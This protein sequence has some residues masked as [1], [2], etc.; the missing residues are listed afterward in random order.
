MNKTELRK[1]ILQKRET[2]PEKERLILKNLLSMKEFEEA[3][4]ILTYV[5]AAGEIDTRELIN[6]CFE[7]G[8]RVAIPKITDSQTVRSMAFFEIESLHG[9]ARGKFGIL[10]P[11]ISYTEAQINKNAPFTF[12]VTPALAYNT[13]GFRLGRGGG[14]YDRFLADYNGTS[15]GLCYEE[16][17]KDFPVEAH[18]VPVN[19][20][21]TEGG[22][23]VV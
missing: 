1:K 12:C 13:S 17:I 5:S 11:D 3:E 8:K 20:I 10:E 22:V 6:R 7:Y 9:L 2:C 19:F 4:L 18:D 16:N 21:I 15:A 23:I 14:F